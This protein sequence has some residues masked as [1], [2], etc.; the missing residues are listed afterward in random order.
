L[1]SKCRS[2][3]GLKRTA[4]RR[5]ISVRRRKRLK[6][7]KRSPKRARRARKRRTGRRGRGLV[8]GKSQRRSPRRRRK[9]LRGKEE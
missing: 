8:T 2:W 5:R 3:R 6:R 7:T 1:S 4:R 9:N